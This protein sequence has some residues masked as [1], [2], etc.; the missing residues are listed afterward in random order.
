MSVLVDAVS[1]LADV[2]SVVVIASALGLWIRGR[3][4][5]VVRA[6]NADRRHA[7]GALLTTTG[8]SKR[9]VRLAVRKCTM[10]YVNGEKAPTI[11]AELDWLDDMM[12]DRLRPAPV[13]YYGLGGMDL[14]DALSALSAAYDA[15]SLR[16]RSRGLLGGGTSPLLESLAAT[17]E[18]L[19]R[20][21]ARH[22]TFAA[23]T[24]P[25]AA[26]LRLTTSGGSTQ[27]DLSHLRPTDAPG[28]GVDDIAVSYSPRRLI[29]PGMQSE[30]IASLD[31]IETSSLDLDLEELAQLR[32]HLTGGKAF[33][34]VLPS[35]QA[36]R[37]ERDPASGR[38][39]L[40]CVLAEASFSSVLAS[41]YVGDRGVG[42]RAEELTGE[43]GLFTLAVLPET[44]DG[45]FVLTTRTE[46]VS[47]AAG[48][49]SPAV[50]GN[51]EMRDRTGL[52]VDRD[53]DGIPDPLLALSR[54]CREELGLEVDRESI[55]ILGTMQFESPSEVGTTVLLTTT[56][57]HRSLQEVADDSRY[58]DRLEGAW[59]SEEQIIGVPV[60]KDVNECLELLAWTLTDP[61]H[62][63]HVS[64][65]LV[66]SCYPLIRS[67]LGP[68][69]TQERIGELCRALE[70][71]AAPDGITSAR[72]GGMS[73]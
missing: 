67:V 37:V 24:S 4:P 32:G 73:R 27:L 70:P 38:T 60:P 35:L 49:V 21:F 33:D 5:L 19:T 41:H 13:A 69:G 15:L 63:P 64:G 31:R 39:R 56:K 71:A 20:V 59:E 23:G 6:L 17:A 48:M 52:A 66:A 58:A 72:P 68:V 1:V 22:A 8:M 10:Q 45:F 29:V 54:E 42:R 40:H 62:V 53:P 46:H 36:S 43:A 12:R 7:L 3:N 16:L 55:E 26:E 51:L 61:S 30:K 9:A 2:L 11:Q 28:V 14:S 65:C 18:G 47:I 50:T 34:G 44:S 25:E 57:L